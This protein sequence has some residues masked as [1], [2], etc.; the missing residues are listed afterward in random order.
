MPP[1]VPPQTAKAVARCFPMKVALMSESELGMII[2]APSPWTKRPAI[3]A[4][5]VFANPIHALASTNSETPATKMRRRPRMSARRPAAMR[6]AAN[7]REYPATAHCV[8]LVRKPRSNAIHGRATFTT[9]VSSMM[10]DT[11]RAT[12][13]K[14]FH[15]GAVCEECPFTGLSCMLRSL[16]YVYGIPTRFVKTTSADWE[17]RTK[18]T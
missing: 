2:A 14:P 18:T 15:G 11:P 10:S 3:T 7:V 9:V 16:P 6:N 8:S 17:H 12:K 13:S 5:L 4:W 1:M